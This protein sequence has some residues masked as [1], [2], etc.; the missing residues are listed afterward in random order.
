LVAARFIDVLAIPL[1]KVNE[2]FTIAS[3]LAQGNRS[4]FF[5]AYLMEEN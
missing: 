3:N 2:I 4:S 1:A 5:K